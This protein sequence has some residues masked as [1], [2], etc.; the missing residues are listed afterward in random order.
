ML[1]LRLG[2]PAR[3]SSS[4]WWGLRSTFIGGAAVPLPWASGPGYESRRCLPVTVAYV[5]DFA[6]ALPELDS[7]SLRAEFFPVSHCSLRSG[8]VLF[9]M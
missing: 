8:R 1:G 5:T 2:V 7:H 3:G 4:V 9:H 6:L